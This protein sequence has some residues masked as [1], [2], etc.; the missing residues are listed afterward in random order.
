MDS[1]NAARNIL[2]ICY[3]DE[4]QCEV[5][6]KRLENYRKEW[7]EHLQTYKNS[8]LHDE[9]S[10]GA[11]AFQTLAMGHD[12]QLGAMAKQAFNVKR[13]SSGGWT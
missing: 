1:I 6:L 12:F 4:N 5:G 11:D 8:P 3:F 2:G 9:N 10:N 7:N 13:A